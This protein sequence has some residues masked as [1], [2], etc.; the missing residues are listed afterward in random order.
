LAIT[1]T[2]NPIF[3]NIVTG[4][5]VDAFDKALNSGFSDNIE[6]IIREFANRV[7]VQPDTTDWEGIRILG[8]SLAQTLRQALDLKRRK[9]VLSFFLE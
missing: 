7:Q 9:V 2:E 1:R 6:N 3:I 5:W 4:V 8:L